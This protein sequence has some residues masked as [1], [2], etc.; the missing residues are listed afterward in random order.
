[1]KHNVKFILEKRLKDGKLIINDVPIIAQITYNGKRIF[2]FTGYRINAVRFNIDKQE[3]NKNSFGKEGTKKVQYNDINNRLT[4]IK[5]KLIEIFDNATIPPDKKFIVS[6]LNTICKKII[7][8]IENINK[9]IFYYF[10]IY[11]KHAGV[12]NNRLKS[13]KSYKN[14]LLKY[15]ESRGIN[16]TFE[17]FTAETLKDFETYLRNDIVKKGDNTIGSIM[18]LLRTFWNYS[19]SNFEN[20]NINYPFKRGKNSKGYSIPK[21]K[22][23]EPIYLTIR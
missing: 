18:K 1:M 14:H 10:D 9:D 13:I 11:I 20:L 7:N 17:N 22:Y 4:Q 21:E 15:T 8:E 5:S 6:E 23:G 12:T 19:I 2:Y 16:L 3:V